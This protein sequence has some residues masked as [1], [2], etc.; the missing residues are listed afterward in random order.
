MN[1]SNLSIDTDPNRLDLDVI[2]GFLANS[3][4]ARGIP[5]ETVEQAVRNSFCFGLYDGDRQVGFARVVTDYATFAYLADV[6]VLE[7]HRGHGLGKRLI[8][9]VMTHAKLQGFRRWLLATRDAHELY[10]RVG[11]KPLAVPERFMELHVPD[12]YAVR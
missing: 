2:H 5:R 7:S 11:F 12:V 4:W 10:T 6:F 9:A 3:Y 8:D 1:L